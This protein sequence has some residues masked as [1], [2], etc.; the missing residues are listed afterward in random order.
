MPQCFSQTHLLAYHAESN[1]SARLEKSPSSGHHRTSAY[2]LLAGLMLL[3]LLLAAGRT[4]GEELDLYRV[5]PDD[6]ISITVFGEPELSLDK[7]RVATDGK[8]SFPLL[9]QIPVEGLSVTEIEAELIS[10]LKDGYLKK[11][12]VTVAITEYRLFYVNGEVRSPGGYSYRDGLTVQ[13]A[14][15]LAGGFT[16]RASMRKITLIHEDAPS[17]RIKV[18]LTDLLQPGDI[19]TVGESFF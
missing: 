8:I 7:V 5:A 1:L 12:A 16:E 10:R 11:P 18:K 15:T 2:R 6:I 13:K 4:Q 3:S 19:I 9:G 14:V 17:Q